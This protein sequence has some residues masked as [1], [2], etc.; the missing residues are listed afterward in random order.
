MKVIY[1]IVSWFIS[2]TGIVSPF[3][4]FL[5]NV[6]PNNDI[7]L[8]S[9]PQVQQISTNWLQYIV[10][11]VVDKQKNRLEVSQ[12]TTSSG[13]YELEN[14]HIVK[15]IN[16]LE[17]YI[18]KYNHTD[19]LFLGWAPRNKN[20]PEEV[21]FIVVACHDK[22]T[23]YFSIKQLVQ[24]PHWESSQIESIQLKI[25]LMAIVNVK[26]Y[27]AL[28]LRELYAHNTRYFLAWEIWYMQ[29]SLPENSTIEDL[30]S[31]SNE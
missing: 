2:T 11:D 12:N 24:S 14:L 18:Q 13:L 20:N 29:M 8:L 22:N 3:R 5:P 6:Y 7:K 17:T 15:D 19:D 31:S 16:Q 27:T 23:N 28:D 25:A 10:T 1:I 30:P 4:K 9:L 21:L 26:N